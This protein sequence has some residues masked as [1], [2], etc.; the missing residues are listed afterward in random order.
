MYRTIEARIISPGCEGDHSRPSSTQV[1]N[2]W[3][4][5]SVPAICFMVWTVFCMFQNAVMEVES[6]AALASKLGSHM[7]LSALIQV[8]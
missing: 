5:T 3:S 1:K 4:H 8:T 2:Q 7:S 6:G